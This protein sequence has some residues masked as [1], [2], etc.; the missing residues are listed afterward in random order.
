MG[1][2]KIDLSDGDYIIRKLTPIEVERAFTIPDNYTKYGK[3]KDGSVKQISNT[4]RY[5]MLG[6]GFV[7]DVLVEGILKNLGKRKNQIKYYTIE[8]Y[9]LD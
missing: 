7:I 3:F 6:N 1:L 5:K 8:D 4:Q 2:Y 9:L